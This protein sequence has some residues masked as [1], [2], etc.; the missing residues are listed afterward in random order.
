MGVKKLDSI[1]HYSYATLGSVK[2]VPM[3]EQAMSV[4]YQLLARSGILRR[5]PEGHCPVPMES[6][7][8]GQSVVNVVGERGVR[9]VD[10][11]RAPPH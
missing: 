8:I 3:G 6:L 5:L 7:S 2:I 9:T 4:D 1:S 10:G 11:D